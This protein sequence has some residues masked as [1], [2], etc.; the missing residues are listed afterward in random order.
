MCIFSRAVHHVSATKLFARREGQIQH[1]IY[2]MNFQAENP[3]AMILP[4][5]TPNGSPEDA[6][7]FLDLSGYPEIFKDLDK[8]FPEPQSRGMSR[9]TKGMGGPASPRLRVH[10][11]GSF[12]ASFAPSSADLNR[13]DEQF[14][15][16]EDIAWKVDGRY[17]GWGYVVAKLKPN[18]GA[19][20]VHPLAFNFPTR[21]PEG[22][23]FFPTLHVHNGSEL[24]ERADF[25]HAIY[26][27]D[28]PAAPNEGWRRAT[29]PAGRHVNL[30]KAKGL[31]LEDAPYFKRTIRG[32]E[33][34]EDVYVR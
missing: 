22:E 34:N 10:S 28:R 14:R 20:A 13:L 26:F 17:P 8:G 12:N 27:Q 29:T 32:R 24:E 25:D 7:V 31:V 5:P 19:Q 21:L 15:L 11:V 2:A 33:R 3:L 30:A 4:T 23:I 16:P 6:T 9:G 18:T 1:L